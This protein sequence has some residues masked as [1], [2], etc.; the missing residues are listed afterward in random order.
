MTSM[1]KYLPRVN[2]N[3][4][5]PCLGENTEEDKQKFQQNWKKRTKLFK[6]FA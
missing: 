4:R 6:D 1:S 5:Q 3:A 2:T